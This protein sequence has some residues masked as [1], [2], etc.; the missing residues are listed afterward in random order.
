ME[1]RWK[2]G[3][4]GSLIAF[5]SLRNINR[6]LTQLQPCCST[7]TCVHGGV[8]GQSWQ[9][10]VWS[11]VERSRCHDELGW[12]AQRGCIEREK[13]EPSHSVPPY[14]AHHVLAPCL[15]QAVRMLDEC[16][17]ILESSSQVCR[18]PRCQGYLIIGI[19]GATPM[20]ACIRFLE[21]HSR[22]L[23]TAR[24]GVHRRGAIPRSSQH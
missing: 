5:Q 16:G 22:S 4:S 9:R 24:A 2:Q 1:C 15:L 13:K 10:R 7:K 11:G 19:P 21:L 23:P 6:N 18:I 14:G 8:V 17:R 20:H 12:I 3:R